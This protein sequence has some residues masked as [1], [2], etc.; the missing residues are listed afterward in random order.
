MC[1][2]F[3]NDLDYLMRFS[4]RRR[5][6]GRY[7]PSRSITNAHPWFF[8]RHWSKLLVRI[9]L[10]GKVMLVTRIK[11]ASHCSKEVQNHV[12]RVKWT[13]IS[14]QKQSRKLIQLFSRKLLFPEMLKSLWKG[15]RRERDCRHHHLPKMSHSVNY[16]IRD[17]PIN[18]FF[19]RHYNLFHRD[20]V[21]LVSLL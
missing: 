13:S 15:M 21:I 6:S 11:I 8:R 4:E 16:M 19:L 18:I 12:Q 5:P 2:F 1:P 17:T 14:Y 20:I 10:V 9:P 3:I 7:R